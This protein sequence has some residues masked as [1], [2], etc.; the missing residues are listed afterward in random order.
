MEAFDFNIVELQNTTDTEIVQGLMTEQ[1]L[2]DISKKS[3][4]L[5]TLDEIRTIQNG[6]AIFE[7]YVPDPEY[8]QRGVTF[9]VTDNHKIEL[10]LNKH[11]KF[12]QRIWLLRTIVNKYFDALMAMPGR[13]ELVY[14]YGLMKVYDQLLIPVYPEVKHIDKLVNVL[15]FFIMKC[16]IPVLLSF[17]YHWPQIS[18]N[19][20]T[21]E[22]NL[23]E[24][25]KL[26]YPIRIKQT[27]N[28]IISE[29]MN[30]N[31]DRLLYQVKINDRF[32]GAH[33][34]IERYVKIK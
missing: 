7:K 26:P 15:V 17:D 18:L 25:N 28:A 20:S 29:M 6:I 8:A 10:T 33:T 24:L 23:D 14:P 27:C 2:E 22:Q 19:V 31:Y 21:H 34:H 3:S 13:F 4:S 16:H 11:L 12:G 9:T 30:H 32:S 1:I 5:L